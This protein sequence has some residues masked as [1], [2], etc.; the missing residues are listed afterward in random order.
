MTPPQHE[1]YNREPPDEG[2]CGG[3]QPLH[4][5]FIALLPTPSRASPFHLDSQPIPVLPFSAMETKISL[6]ELSR[7]TGISV[8][9]LSRIFGAKNR[10]PSLTVAAT[11]AKARGITLDELY[12][13]IRPEAAA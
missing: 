10:L 8:S 1:W 9:H 4:F 11:I 7:R 12:H 3:E 2:G 6:H 13:E 5:T